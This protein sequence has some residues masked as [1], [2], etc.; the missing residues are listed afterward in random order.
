MRRGF[1]LLEMMLSL[2]ILGVSLGI[3]AQ[4]A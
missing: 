3:L 4:I 1:S 2:A